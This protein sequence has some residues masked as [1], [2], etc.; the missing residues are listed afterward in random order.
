ML[1]SL[2]ALLA[3][4]AKPGMFQRLLKRMPS[5]KEIAS[6]GAGLTLLFFVLVGVTAPPVERQVAED[7]VAVTDAGPEAPEDGVAE[8]AEEK[9]VAEAAVA[10][11][12]NDTAVMPNTDSSGESAAV[13]P[14]AAT[15]EYY[16]V[17]SVVDGDTFKVAIGGVTETVRLIGID[18]PESVDPRKSVE[19]FATEAS[20]QAKKLLSGKRVKLAADP[21]Q[22]ER[23]KYRRLLRYAW[24]EDGAF[25]N[26][27]M[28]ADG[29][30][31]EYTYDAPYQYQAA[32]K[33]AQAE[34]QAAKRGLW[35][36]A[37]CRAEEPA[38]AQPASGASEPTSAPAPAASQPTGYKFYV[39]S[40]YSS[41]YY[42]CET[43]PGWQ[44]LSEKYLEAYPSEA[45]LRTDY[46]RHTL[47]APC[48]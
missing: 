41:K 18:T 38:P 12:S 1:A 3:G 34:A 23:D 43:D 17:T 27:Q 32:F 45:A 25:F 7:S 31:M 35:A 44:G 14:E 21:T 28:I 29:Y 2:A 46:P 30:A 8:D 47:H 42:Y 5:R 20:N 19:C 16:A 11:D 15:D 9:E 22:G 40:H 24:L 48:E 36:D 39:S 37:A 26:Q 33:Q 10:P 4:L 13:Q 6:T